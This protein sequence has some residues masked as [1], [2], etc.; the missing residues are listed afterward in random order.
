MLTRYPGSLL[1]AD[2]LSFFALDTVVH[3][4]FMART[5]VNVGGRMWRIEHHV[6]TYL[7]SL[8]GPPQSER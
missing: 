2:S 6:K 8:L 4:G 3:E 1:V 7:L 5:L